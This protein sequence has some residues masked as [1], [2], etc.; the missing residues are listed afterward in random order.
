VR[1]TITAVRTREKTGAGFCSLTHAALWLLRRAEHKSG[2]PDIA[3]DLH[4][5]AVLD[6]AFK[7]AEPTPK[8]PE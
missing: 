8:R 6:S 5:K 4:A 3:S 7:L 1:V 2:E